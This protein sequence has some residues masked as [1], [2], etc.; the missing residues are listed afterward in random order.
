MKRACLSPL[1]R[2]VV[3]IIKQSEAD[4]RFR[5]ADALDAI[6]VETAGTREFA[7]DEARAAYHWRWLGQYVA[8]YPE[9]VYLALDNHDTLIGYLIGCLDDPARTPAFDAIGYLKDFADLTLHYPAHL[10]INL[11]AAARGHGIGTALIAAFAKD[12]AAAGSPGLHVVTGADQRNV[13]FYEGN[14][15]HEA[16]RTDWHGK[17]LLFLGRKL[18]VAQQV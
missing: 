14:G 6:F 2:A 8:H 12:A 13:G 16:G 4:E 7:T 3:T 15:F 17:P 11:T 9:W 18:M 5:R 1:E 10:H